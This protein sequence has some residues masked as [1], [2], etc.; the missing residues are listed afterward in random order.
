M[1]CEHATAT[2]ASV[3]CVHSR[4][5]LPQDPIRPARFLN[6]VKLDDYEVVNISQPHTN[7]KTDFD[8]YGL[9]TF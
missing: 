8:W 7:D 5:C 4:K 3:A 6:G 1:E 2:V 9:Q